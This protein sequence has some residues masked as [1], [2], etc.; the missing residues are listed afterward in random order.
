MLLVKLNNL[1]TSAWL[2]LNYGT[3]KQKSKMK[4][5]QRWW[6][7]LKLVTK[8]LTSLI[9]VIFFVPVKWVISFCLGE[10]FA[11]GNERKWKASIFRLTNVSSSNLNTINLK[12]FQGPRPDSGNDRSKKVL[13]ALEN[14]TKTNLQ[15]NIPGKV[16]FQ[17]KWGPCPLL[18]TPPP[19]VEGPVFHNHG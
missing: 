2:N 8:S 16:R 1:Q 6:N 3:T 19:I 5:L 12:L 18:A 9:L 11:W 7:L 17:K 10:R 15:E 13:D 4:S 14:D